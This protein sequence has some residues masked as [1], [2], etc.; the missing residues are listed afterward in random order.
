MHAADSDRSPS[1]PLDLS[2]G[3]VQRHWQE[4]GVAGLIRAM[5]RCEPW[6]VDVRPESK[7]QAEAVV[8]EVARLFND[9]GVGV[10]ST[11]VTGEP[12]LMIDFM[13]YMRTGRALALFAWLAEVHPTIPQLLVNQARA[14]GDEF[15]SILIERIT[16]LEK[17]H[18]LSRVFSAERI[19][20]VLEL[21]AEAGLSLPD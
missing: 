4:Q 9:S 19:S 13:G 10:I 3:W 18:L 20:L 16:T 17:Q 1:V 2:A 8:S 12:A 15:G 11:S 14:G 21:L 6:A 7:L 5:E